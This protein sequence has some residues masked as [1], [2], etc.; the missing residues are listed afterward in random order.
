MTQLKA[1]LLDAGN[2]LIHVD[3]E[4]I[5]E[6]LAA[7]GVSADE[8]DYAVARRYA[9]AAVARILGSDD[10]G[11]DETR[12]RAWFIALVARLGLPLHRVPAV[13][14]D[15]RKRH[16]EGL[17][18]VRAEPGTRELLEGLRAAGLR[19]AVVSNA[20]GRVDRYLE[21]AGLADCFEFVLDSGVVGIEKPDP[22]IFQLAC[23]RLGMS[24]DEVV[25]VGDSYEVDVV[26]A[27]A[28]GI[29]A[30]LLVDEPRDGVA[31][32]SAITELPNAL[33]LTAVSD[34]DHDR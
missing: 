9:H 34:S 30:I 20:D 17:L 5:L 10:P 8:E 1:V 16:E 18:W 32:I 29:E 11:T 4:F 7:E 21:T 25:Y 28:A 19:L 6:R 23:E 27:R 24:P 14:D 31:C 33:G 26:G 15:I 2:T 22:R 3:H 13:G 12:I